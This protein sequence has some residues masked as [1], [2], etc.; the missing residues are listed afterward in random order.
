M[1][2]SPIHSHPFLLNVFMYV[3]PWGKTV[4]LSAH[5]LA[6]EGAFCGVA[7]S[8]EDLGPGNGVNCHFD[9]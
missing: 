2:T 8:M 6:E 4:S 9:V 5:T 7:K 3:A 1:N